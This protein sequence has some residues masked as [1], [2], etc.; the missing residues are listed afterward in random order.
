LK[1]PI[2]RRERFYNLFQIRDKE[3]STS[4]L[5]VTENQVGDK[6]DH[7][8]IQITYGKTSWR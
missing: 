7:N 2:W 5:Q 8:V 1:K 3:D 6:G 4:L